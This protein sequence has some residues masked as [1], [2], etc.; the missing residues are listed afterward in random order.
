MMLIVLDF[1]SQYFL[2]VNEEKKLNHIAKRCLKNLIFCS[3]L[4][5]LEMCRLVKAGEWLYAIST[6]DIYH[7]LINFPVKAL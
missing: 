3:R 1:S 7:I 2:T 5:L 4:S 6:Y